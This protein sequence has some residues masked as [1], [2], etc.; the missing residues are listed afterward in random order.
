[1]NLILT[2][3]GGI[4][5]AVA[6]TSLWFAFQRPSFVIGLFAEVLRTALP[7]L[8]PRNLNPDEK[9]RLARGKSIGNEK[10]WGHEK[11]VDS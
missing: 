2:L 8:K 7:M 9:D 11:G 5:F 6:V 4:A 3:A 10:P 1:M